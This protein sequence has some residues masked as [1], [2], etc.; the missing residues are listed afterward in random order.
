MSAFHPMQ[1]SDDTWSSG[2]TAVKRMDN[3][4]IVVDDPQGTIATR[5]QSINSPV[6]RIDRA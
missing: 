5:I 2:F 3:V 1:T 6:G 4:G